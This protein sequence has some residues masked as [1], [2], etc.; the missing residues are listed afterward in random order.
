[1]SLIRLFQ[2]VHISQNILPCTVSTHD[3]YSSILSEMLAATPGGAVAETCPAVQR[4]SPP[5]AQKQINTVTL[6]P[7]KM[8]VGERTRRTTWTKALGG[9]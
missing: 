8:T 4:G 1:M 5:S 7:Y 2:N 9:P 6:K 3:F